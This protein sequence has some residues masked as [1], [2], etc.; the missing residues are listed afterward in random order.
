M[1]LT[2]Q[3]PK[4][5]L[6]LPLEIRH[7]FNIF[8]AKGRL[9]AGTGGTSSNVVDTY[10]Q[11][12]DNAKAIVHAVSTYDAREAEI[13][14]L[15]GQ[16]AEAEN[17]LAAVIAQREEQ[18]TDAQYGFYPELQRAIRKARKALAVVRKAKP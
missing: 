15:R 5:T 7:E 12:V 13:E 4:A 17:G 8:T 18:R 10:S 9:L 11:N 2:E 16:L 6:D 3:F 14:R 1:K